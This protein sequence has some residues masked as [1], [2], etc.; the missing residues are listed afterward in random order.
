M[1]LLPKKSPIVE[2][3]YPGLC[4]K[5]G[6]LFERR[7]RIIMTTAKEKAHEDCNAAPVFE[8]TAESNDVAL[9]EFSEAKT[10]GQRAWCRSYLVRAGRGPIQPRIDAVT[11]KDADFVTALR[12]GKLREAERGETPGR[13]SWPQSCRVC[14]G[15]MD[16]GERLFYRLKGDGPRQKA[17]HILQ[18][19]PTEWRI[20]KNAAG[21]F[22]EDLR[23]GREGVI[24]HLP[25]RARSGFIQV[26]SIGEGAEQTYQR[27]IARADSRL[28]GNHYIHKRALDEGLKFTSEKVDEPRLPNEF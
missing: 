20:T 25:K 28:A 9:F 4:I 27:E 10:Q 18:C 6:G 8:K 7:A 22:Y 16:Y 13:A 21:V 26:K 17:R 3:F 19:S 2:A 12:A 24:W 1:G 23:P 15:I 5:C 11:E 14:D